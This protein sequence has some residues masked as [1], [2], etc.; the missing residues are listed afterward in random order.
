[1]V[2]KA[3]AGKWTDIEEGRIPSGGLYIVSVIPTD[4][5]AANAT[6]SIIFSASSKGVALSVNAGA[7]LFSTDNF[8]PDEFR[9]KA[10]FADSFILQINP[11]KD[12]EVHIG[13]ILSYLPENNKRN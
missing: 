12:S 8:V 13:K 4:E 2:D 9:A 1:M 10:S 3:E 7:M 6:Y 5:K 11:T